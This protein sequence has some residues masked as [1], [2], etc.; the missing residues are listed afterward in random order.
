MTSCT[1]CGDT[2]QPGCQSCENERLRAEIAALKGSRAG[3][4]ASEARGQELLRQYQEENA[5]LRAELREVREEE[6]MSEKAT[7]RPWYV[8]KD[9]YGGV[10]IRTK[11]S[12]AT[13]IVGDDAI[14]ENTGRGAGDMKLEDAELIIAAVNACQVLGIKPADLEAKVRALVEALAEMQAAAPQQMDTTRGHRLYL[15]NRQADA[16]L[17]LFRKEAADAD[18]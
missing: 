8:G 7:P 2:P 16:A 6:A 3:L 1:R 13:N 14:F 18:A 12:L 9:Y 5:A 11:P 10:S 17:A 15:A 4:E